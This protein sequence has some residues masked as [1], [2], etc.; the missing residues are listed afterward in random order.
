MTYSKADLGPR[1]L[2]ALVDALIGVIPAIIPIIGAL[3][4]VAYI[5]SKDGL[6]YQITKQEEWKNR[7]IGKKLFDLQVVKRDGGYVDIA[8]SAKRNLPL[9]IG[10]IIAI[11]PI[12]GWALGPIIGLICAA[13]ELALI[14]SDVQGRRMGDRWANTQ[15]VAGKVTIYDQQD[16]ED[17]GN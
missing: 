4:S 1:I 12:L 16:T 2:A 10:S 7:S 9:A 11:I 13:I 17:L 8:V 14:F 5:L 15:V 6:M 3:V